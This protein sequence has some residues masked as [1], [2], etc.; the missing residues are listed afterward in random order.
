MKAITLKE[1]FKKGLNIVEKIVGRNLTLPILNNIL[2]KADKNF[3]ILMATNLEIGVK[4]WVLSKIEK[5]GSIVVPTKVLS[6][7]ISNISDE[8]ISITLKDSR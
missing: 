2:L 8:K 6:T 7:F 3:I 1:N 4:Y 5:E